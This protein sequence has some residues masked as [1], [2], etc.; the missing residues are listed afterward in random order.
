MAAFVDYYPGTATIEI[1][2]TELL[3]RGTASVKDKESIPLE[4]PIAKQRESRSTGEPADERERGEYLRGVKQPSQTQ[5][6]KVT[7]TP[8]PAILSPGRSGSTE[9]VELSRSIVDAAKSVEASLGTISIGSQ[10]EDLKRKLASSYLKLNDTTDAAPFLTIVSLAENVLAGTDLVEIKSVVPTLRS[11]F[12]LCFE[13]PHITDID[14]STAS[15]ELAQLNA[16]S[17]PL[18]LLDEQFDDDEADDLNGEE[19]T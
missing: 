18:F 1:P 19:E 9:R 10:V 15:A 13:R 11:V 17:V 4:L 12:R 14:V 8:T 6:S 7:K 3:P 2:S 16:K 5:L